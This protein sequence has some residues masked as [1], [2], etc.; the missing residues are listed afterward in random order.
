MGRRTDIAEFIQEIKE[1]AAE[2]GV[3][4][5]LYPDGDSASRIRNQFPLGEES[6]DLHVTLAYLGTL[7]QLPSDMMEKII[8]IVRVMSTRTDPFKARLNGMGHFDRTPEGA[9]PIY[10]NVDSYH[11]EDIRNAIVPPLVRLGILDRTHGYT[12]HMTVM[13]VDPEDQN[14]VVPPSPEGIVAFNA[15][16]LVAGD[17]RS[18]YPFVDAEGVESGEVEDPNQSIVDLQED[19]AMEAELETEGEI[20][21]EAEVTAAE[22]T[23]TEAEEADE[24]L[25]DLAG[26]TFFQ[27][28]VGRFKKLFEKSVHRDMLF[29]TVYER[30]C[31]IVYDV[32]GD[33]GWLSDILLDDNGKPFGL[34]MAQGRLYKLPIYVSLDQVMI[35]DISEVRLSYTPT[36]RYNIKRTITGTYEGFA[37]MGT[38]AVNKD[39]EIDSRA[40]FDCFV[41][42]FTQT[43]EYINIYHLGEDA[44]KIGRVAYIFRENNL[45]VGYLIFDDTPIGRIVGETLAAD[46]EGIWGSSIEYYPDNVEGDEILNLDIGIEIPVYNR[47]TF[48]GV[49]IVKSDHGSAWFTGH[50]TRE[51]M[52]RMNATVAKSVLELFRGNEAALEE[53]GQWLESTNERLAPA[54]TRGLEEVIAEDPAPAVTDGN[55]PEVETAV[56]NQELNQKIAELQGELTRLEGLLQPAPLTA[57]PELIEQLRVQLGLPDLTARI[58]DMETKVVDGIT[59]QSAL[60]SGLTVRLDRLQ[61]AQD[62]VSEL[63]PATQRG[64]GSDWR[65]SRNESTDEVDITQGAAILA[66]ATGELFEQM[67][68]A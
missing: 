6:K 52:K 8:E 30:L 56:A 9:I 33:Q 7:N 12:P 27:K 58:G 50:M 24:E 67:R 47:G 21:T 39:L 51:V 20:T 61:G 55:V 62:D 64:N 23:D 63:T 53:L 11:I 5:A 25:A 48:K 34:V 29:S 68:K 32:F 49:S 10:L 22:V 13:Y 19:E 18:D 46:S 35:G 4:I 40:L 37:I 38:A 43:D 3:M 16:S 31:Q 66:R 45:F 44:S 17:W 57:S 65:P 41:E 2:T 26:R 59:A 54:I 36:Q 28:I 15:I 42:R 60:L 1:R 14:A